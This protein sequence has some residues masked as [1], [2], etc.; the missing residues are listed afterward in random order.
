MRIFRKFKKTIILSLIFSMIMPI[1][2]SGISLAQRNDN[3]SSGTHTTVGS[4]KN[5]T[6]AKNSPVIGVD[7]P[8]NPGEVMLFK[9][10]KKVEGKLNTFDVTLR[11]EAKDVS[12]K[13]DIV[14]VIDRSGSMNDN[15]RMKKAKEAAREFIDKLLP[16]NNT[17]ISIVSFASDVRTDQGLTNNKDN[18]K[19]AVDRIYA[20]G[21]TFTQSGIKQAEAILSNSNADNKHIIF[22]SDGEPTFSYLIG[23]GYNADDYF[24]K[25]IN[26]NINIPK[27][28]FTDERIGNGN[29]LIWRKWKPFKYYL[30]HNHGNNAIAQSKYAKA[31]G[32]SIWSVALEAGQTGTK[33]LNAVA[34]PG[35]SYNATPAELNKI[36]NEI[37]GKISSAMKDAHVTDPM[38]AGFQIPVGEVSNIQAVPKNPAPTYDTSVTPHKLIWNPGTVTT[39]IE[40]GSDIKYAEL[41][42]RVVINDHILNVEPDANG[43][44]DTNGNAS[45]SYIDINGNKQTPAFPKPNAKP[46]IIKM[47]KVLLDSRGNKIPSSDGR[48][49]N[50][51]LKLQEDNEFNQDY[52][53]KGNAA[54]VMTDLRIDKHYTLTE[55]KFSGSPSSEQNDYDIDVKWKTWDGTQSGK[56]NDNSLSNWL[57]PKNAN[58]EPL[59]TTV[60]VTNKEKANGKLTIKKTFNPDDNLPFNN[61]LSNLNSLLPKNL[62][63]GEPKYTITVV[64]KSLYSDE[65]IFRQTYELSVG[66]TKEITGLHYGNYKVTEEGKTPNF[67]DSD[68]VN[69]GIVSIKVDKKEASVEIINRPEN[70]DYTTDFEASKTWVNGPTADH[71]APEFKLYADGKDVTDANADKLEITPNNGTAS[72]FTYKW[73]GVKKYNTSGKLINYTVK[74][75]DANDDN[76][77]K[78]N[79]NT[80]TVT[81]N[82]NNITNTYKQ[83]TDGKVEVTKEWDGSEEGKLKRP[84][85]NLTL[86]RKVAGGEEEKVPEAEVKV[87][88][89]TT[90]T[91]KWENLKTKDINGKDYT[92]IVKES[93]KNADDVNNGNWT[94]VE[95]TEVKNGIATIKNKAVSGEENLGKL[96]VKKNLIASGANVRKARGL[97][98]VK[99]EF[100]VTGPNGYEETF[101]LSPGESKELKELYFGE[102]KVEETDT[103][104]YTAS[105]SVVDGKVTL[106]STDKEKTVEVT[107]TSG[108]EGTV[109]EK[110]VEKVWVN[111]PKPSTT[112]ELWRKNNVEGADKIDEK[113]DEFV[114][115]ENASGEGLKKTFE[116]L[117]K[118][119][120]KGNEYEYYVKEEQVPENY[121]KSIEGLK[122]TNTY[123]Q[124]T[125]GKVEVTKEWDGPEEGKLKRPKINLTLY[126]K[127]AGGEEEK[128]PE[129][130][131]KVVDGTTTTAKWENL[132]TKDINGKDYTFVVKESFKN[133]DDVNNGNWTIVESTEVKNGVATIKNKAVSGEENLGKLVVK[134][135]LV[136]LGNRYELKSKKFEFKVIGPNGYE[137]TFKLSPGESKE[138]KELYFGEY[139]VEETD[140]K[141]CKTA[142]S[143]ADGKVTLKSTD[144]VKT[145]EVTNTSTEKVPNGK[146]PKMSISGTGLTMLVISSFA[147]VI[148]TKRRKNR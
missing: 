74:E 19:N 46:V 26:P 109:V 53:V 76:E 49:F 5:L 60:T 78:I 125:D 32:Y 39:P 88:D 85:I 12:K 79:N 124:P 115:A 107:N 63:S 18:L 90:T 75:K 132:K 64:G 21:G 6:R 2:L 41:K 8:I 140:A 117:A 87:V 68:G 134:K 69:D 120:P 25:E 94:I 70:N 9:E 104:G 44:Y 130:E 122:V 52:E 99:F 67:I 93:F 82:G 45:V 43:H 27:E 55:N 112:I 96:T 35:Q 137:E 142:Y 50:F 144:K 108:G 91:A 22:L 119:D 141:G 138:L 103:K 58:G 86:Y 148:L 84:E 38:G 128:V 106:K 116:N 61:F 3:K 59:N 28:A 24:S 47:E 89:G 81:Q 65:E 101:K 72:Q 127:V 71:T 131:V 95:S 15:S 37:A 102:Y 51:N 121:E 29:D 118:H 40:E 114:V 57:V 83:P 4:K 7:H 54:R 42:Y 30:Y 111:G 113:V 139:T 98:P 145:V 56:G 34:S 20:D 66:E 36:F 92:F 48:K 62:R 17:R 33:V 77:F 129:A 147:G 11:M 13:S 16:S 123:K 14:L 110:T 136:V 146:L 31:S 135:N 1:F 105:Y 97:E 73:T 80:Y 126:R 10:V 133:A 143:V 100:K 23:N